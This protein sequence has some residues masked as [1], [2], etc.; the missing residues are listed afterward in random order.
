MSAWKGR[1]DVVKHLLKKGAKVNA[2]GGM[3]DQTPVHWAARGGHSEVVKHLLE[4]G[5]EVN[6]KDDKDRTPIH[7]AAK[8]GCTDVVKH[9]L[10]KGA[11]VNDKDAGCRTPLHWAA[12]EGHFEFVKHLLKKGA[13]VNDKDYEGQTPLHSAAE[14]GH[15]NVV[16][17]LLENGAEVNCMNKRDQTPLHCA[18]E[19]GHTDVVKHLL[20]KG[21]E[22]NSKDDEGQIPLHLACRYLGVIIAGHDGKEILDLSTIKELLKRN[23]ELIAQKDG[24]GKTPYNLFFEAQR[25][26]FESLFRYR[27][28]KRN[29]W[30][31]IEIMEQI[32]LGKDVSLPQHTQHRV[33]C[34]LIWLEL[35]NGGKFESTRNLENYSI[36]ASG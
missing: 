34:S 8:G 19:R 12:R 11:V 22:A 24:L 5:S 7:C 15:F 3:F 10:K 4:K 28:S 26:H 14:E 2:K 16:K 1:F 30:S 18:A 9:L 29:I 13:V 23:P 25:S 36:G 17:H 27:C 32:D 35:E 33:F 20:E 31:F 21:A 6:V